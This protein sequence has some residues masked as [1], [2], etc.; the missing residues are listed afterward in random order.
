MSRLG[1]PAIQ[2]PAASQSFLAKPRTHLLAI[3]AC[4]KPMPS[5]PVSELRA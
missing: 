1:L 3:L 5:W 4:S 2:P